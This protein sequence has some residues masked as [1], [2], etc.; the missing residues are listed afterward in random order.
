MLWCA[1]Y[2]TAP[3]LSLSHD[4]SKLPNIQNFSFLSPEGFATSV[5][6]A[7]SWG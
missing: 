4:V 5:P 2:F 6:A 1:L 7:A 3:Q